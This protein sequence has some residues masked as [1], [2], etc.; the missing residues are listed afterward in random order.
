[1]A[2]MPS[3]SLPPDLVKFV[4]DQLTQGKYG[5]ANEVVCDAIRLLRKREERLVA[6][7]ADVDQGI[8]QISNGEYLELETDDD[9][10]AF[11]NDVVARA[12]ASTD[13]WDN[14]EDDKDWDN[15]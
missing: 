4:A 15:A 9:I 12:A 2:S 14:P 11:F 8:S 6:L 5:S 13:F 10:D 1:M 7:R 3:D